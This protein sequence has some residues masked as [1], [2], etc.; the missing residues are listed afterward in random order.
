MYSGQVHSG[1]PRKE[2]MNYVRQLLRKANPQDYVVPAFVQSRQVYTLMSFLSV[3]LL[4]TSN[5]EQAY[6]LVYFLPA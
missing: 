5:Q 3:Y 6:I 1:V 2:A 4:P